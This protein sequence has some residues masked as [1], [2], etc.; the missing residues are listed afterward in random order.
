MDAHLQ[1]TTTLSRGFRYV[2]GPGPKTPEPST[3][4]AE[5]QY[6][7]PPRPQRLRLK[8]RQ[9]SQLNA[10]TQQFLA[11]IAAADVPIPSVE[12]EW[13]NVQEEIFPHTG[14]D[15]Y[16]IGG[17]PVTRQATP[18]TFARPKTPSLEITTS[19]ST[20]FADWYLDSPWSDSDLESSPDYESSRP[21]TAFS[22]QTSSS[23][24][25][26]YSQITDDESRV[27]PHGK[28]KDVL[29]SD[30]DTRR[31][32]SFDSRTRKA[33][34]TRAM[35]AHL[36]A[37]YILYLSDPRVTPIRQ[38]KSCIPPH[39]VCARVSRQAQRSWKGARMTAN[40]ETRSQM[41]THTAES[42]KAF[43]QWPHTP[44]ATRAHLREICKLKATN[45]SGHCSSESPA[46]FTQV[47]NRRWNRRCTPARSTSVFSAREMAMSLTLS[48]S[49]T[50]QPQGPLAQ[51]TSSKPESE[52]VNVD[53]RVTTPCRDVDE[54]GLLLEAV[55]STGS[56]QDTE[57][58]T[59][60][61][62]SPF[63]AKSYGPSSSTSLAAKL[64]LPNQSNTM[65]A[66]KL[67]KP[68]VRLAN[69]RSGTQKRRSVKGHEEKPWRR[70]SLTAAFF[71][72]GSRNA[73]QLVSTPSRPEPAGE[74]AIPGNQEPLAPVQVTRLYQSASHLGSS[75]ARPTAS[76][77]G[78]SSRLGS[79]FSGANLS[80]SF[81]NRLSSARD[82][83]L[84]ALRRPFATV[85]QS[86][87][88]DA[89]NT[90]APPRSSLASRLAYLDQRLKDFRNRGSD[91]GRS[92]S[93]L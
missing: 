80:H 71:R 35:S 46:P 32:I 74:L 18:R 63:L 69:S 11:S 40:V 3:Q 59:T 82:F 17:E 7:P 60:Q 81:P 19:Q 61:L 47:A 49:D 31:I 53:E 5:E 26:M 75:S 50:M 87:H 42:S 4:G 89:E 83:S 76:L 58:A 91:H 72:E 86:C 88:A 45:K 54:G 93:P 9:V 34:W 65:G 23:L 64:S 92:Q 84:A 27:G 14:C 85:Q 15:T 73:E 22:T 55:D 77:P 43:I 68:P 36:W 24:F 28:A 12:D 33:P 90:T 62:G 79:P 39:G 56:T 6:L 44:A 70:P 29:H 2:D 8:R 41:G 37:T 10:P 21:S 25:S 30:T 20:T 67:L 38:G 13:S 48:T 57:I 66:R 78:R 1:G 16:V 51:L 52:V